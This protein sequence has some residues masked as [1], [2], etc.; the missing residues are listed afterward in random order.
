[1]SRRPRTEDEG[2]YLAEQRADD[3]RY[4]SRAEEDLA[5]DRYERS[6]YA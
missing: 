4:T 3:W 2:E 5:E 6:H 1:M